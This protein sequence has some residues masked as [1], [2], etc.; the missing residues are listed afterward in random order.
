MPWAGLH[1]SETFTRPDCAVAAGVPGALPSAQAEPVGT[2]PSVV[3]DPLMLGEIPNQYPVNGVSDPPG[4]QSGARSE[5]D[6]DRVS[7]AVV[8]ESDGL[9]QPWI[10]MLSELEPDKVQAGAE[11][12]KKSEK[13]VVVTAPQ[14]PSAERQVATEDHPDFAVRKTPR[15]DK[16]EPLAPSLD[17]GDSDSM[18]VAMRKADRDSPV[19][20]AG[21]PI[22]TASGVPTTSPT[23]T[24]GAASQSANAPA[25][26]VETSEQSLTKRDTVVPI[27]EPHRDYSLTQPRLREDAVRSMQI[28]PEMVLSERDD[29]PSDARADE[30]ASIAEVRSGKEASPADAPRTLHMNRAEI[31]R[32]VAQ[33]LVEV[34]QRGADDAIEVSLNPEELGRVRISLTQGDSGLLVA[35]SADRGETLDLLRRYITDLQSDLCRLGYGQAS[36]DFSESGRDHPA[37]ESSTSQNG[38]D[39]ASVSESTSV[40]AEQLPVASGL[41]L[42]L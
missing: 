34:I 17:N 33:G 42:R 3:R 31:V 9:S 21:Q 36:F 22:A 29:V 6:S 16:I 23:Q 11:L 14:T 32:Q 28:H 12:T 19:P 18:L 39:A 4:E 27:S 26:P 20:L 25:I 1:L 15:P 38:G 24:N 40:E 2:E 10:P 5:G 8:V 13:S 30:L 35:L 37:D 41:D 7:A